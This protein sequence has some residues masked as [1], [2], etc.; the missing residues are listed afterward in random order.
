M[1]RPVV[2]VDHDPK[3]KELAADEAGRIAEALG[4]ALIAIHHIG[5][6][7][8][9]GIKAKPI[10]D[11]L[12]IVKDL[13]SLE[14]RSPALER[15]GYLPR[16]EAGIAGHRYFPKNTQGV[17]THHLHCF[18][19]GHS[20]IYRNLLFRDY[21]IAHPQAA[22][23]YQQVKEDLARKFPDDSNAYAE[24]KTPFIRRT[25]EAARAWAADTRLRLSVGDAGLPSDFDPR[26]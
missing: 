21:L 6:T 10:I 14:G 4:D 12:A 9:P 3:W 19:V 8:I 13:A 15:I 17:R 2:L 25:D 7:S 16:G 24:A 26:S 5:S 18:A 23:E 22:L 11:L 1:P 20:G